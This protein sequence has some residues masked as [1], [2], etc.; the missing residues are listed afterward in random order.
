MEYIKGNK[1]VIFLLQKGN[2]YE[3]LHHDLQKACE[4]YGEA[5]SCLER[6]YGKENRLCN[7]VH[8]YDYVWAVMLF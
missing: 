5:R 7:I 2:E 3:N 1:N 4:Y 8:L 6:L